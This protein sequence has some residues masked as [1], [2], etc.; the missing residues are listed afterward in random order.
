MPTSE[1]NDCRCLYFEHLKSGSEMELDLE[2]KDWIMYK[3]D[4]KKN[5][6]RRRT[7]FK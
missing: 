7:A 6:G 5:D 1:P 3:E 4:N 2:R